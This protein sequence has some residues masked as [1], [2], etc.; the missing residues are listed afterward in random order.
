MM[1][2]RVKVM[3]IVGVVV[4]A[5]VGA[6]WGVS[7]YAGYR[8][9]KKWEKVQAGM[10]MREV[11]MLLGNPEMQFPDADPPRIWAYRLHFEHSVV[12]RPNFPYFDVVTSFSVDPP[13]FYAVYF[14]EEGK[15]L[16]KAR[17]SPSEER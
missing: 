7:R 10:T 16:K 14:S 6:W 13:A 4:L 17:P 9:E 1:R 15:V 8:F 5:M 11:R 3:V 2:K 12:A